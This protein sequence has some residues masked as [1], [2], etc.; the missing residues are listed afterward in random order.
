M[1]N[2]FSSINIK[3][4]TKIENSFEHFVN[5]KSSLIVIVVTFHHFD[6]H[7]HKHNI[8]SV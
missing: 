7:K 3:M 5:A 1:L 4:K 6:V 8:K 2:A